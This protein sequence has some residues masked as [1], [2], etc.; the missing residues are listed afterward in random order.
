MK[1]IFPKLIEDGRIRSGAM[2]TKSD[3]PA[4]VFLVM[5]PWRTFLKLVVSSAAIW[6]QEGMIGPAWDHVSVSHD[7]RTP[8]WDEMAWVKEQLFEAEECVVQFHPPASRYVNL[9]QH[10][11]HL[12]RLADSPFPMP[13]QECV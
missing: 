1:T 4:G 8:S 6:Q 9:H 2:A 10:C 12:W 11:L 5:S 3:D 13:P 7:L